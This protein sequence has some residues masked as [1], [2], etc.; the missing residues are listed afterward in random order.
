MR[1]LIL[2]TMVLL[3]TGCKCQPQLVPNYVFPDPPATLMVPGKS[4]K[5]I[6]PPAA[7]TPVTNAKSS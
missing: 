2:F 1:S 4:L 7:G 5:T 6:Q 3:I